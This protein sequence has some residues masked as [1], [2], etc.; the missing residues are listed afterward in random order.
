L[1]ELPGSWISAS[2]YGRPG[3]PSDVPTRCCLRACTAFGFPDD[4]KKGGV[5]FQL[6]QPPVA[7]EANWPKR[8]KEIAH[9][10][11]ARL[12]AGCQAASS[13]AGRLPAHKR[14]CPADAWSCAL[15]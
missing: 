13:P 11:G 8:R 5:L 3:W 6:R 9:R 10:P 1:V 4:F 12:R 15:P 2:R 14:A 7:P